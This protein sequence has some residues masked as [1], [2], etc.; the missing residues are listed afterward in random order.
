MSFASGVSGNP[1]GRP[2]GAKSATT[3]SKNRQR[4]A[5]KVLENLM[6]DVDA[7]PG[8]KLQAAC[9]ILFNQNAA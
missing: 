6:L 7:K 3:V 5:V 4:A 8:I 9:A 2:R 1:N